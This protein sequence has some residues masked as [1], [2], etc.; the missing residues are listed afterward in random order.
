MRTE[1]EELDKIINKE[2]PHYV[3][4]IKIVFLL[5]IILLGMGIFKVFSDQIAQNVQNQAH[6]TSKTLDSILGISTDLS[7]I[8]AIGA[9]SDQIT[10]NEAT[11]K[12]LDVKNYVSQI[13]SSGGTQSEKNIMTGLVDR[14]YDNT[15]LKVLQDIISGLPQD[16]Q[17]RLIEKIEK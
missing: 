9:V 2:K 14:I 4:Y 3:V 5:T 13:A 10:K 15:I 6:A 7:N 11:K 17:D 8:P 16:Q 12:V 1:E